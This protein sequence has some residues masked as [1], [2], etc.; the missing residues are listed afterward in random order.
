MGAIP[1]DGTCLSR[2]AMAPLSRSLAAPAGIKERLS[3]ESVIGIQRGDEGKGKVACYLVQKAVR[4]G[5][6]TVVARGAGGDN[7]GHTRVTDQGVKVATHLIPASSSI[8]GVSA[9]I[10]GAGTVVSLE[11]LQKEAAEIAPL[12][13]DLTIYIAGNCTLVTAE[14]RRRDAE[15]MKRIGSTGRGIGPAMVDLVNRVGTLVSSVDPKEFP[16]CL[17]VKVYE[18]IFDILPMDRR[19]KVIMENPQGAS[20][21]INRGTYPYVTSSGTGTAVAVG[22]AGLPMCCVTRIF[23]VAKAYRTS[24]GVDPKPQVMGDEMSSLLAEVGRE[25]GVTTGRRRRVDYLDASEII[26]YG[27]EEGV[28][29]LCVTKVDL[30]PETMGDIDSAYQYLGSDGKTVQTGSVSGALTT[31]L[32]Q[33]VMPVADTSMVVMIGTG[34]RDS[35]VEWWNLVVPA[36]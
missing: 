12:N 14:H 1:S 36:Y 20:L 7:C 2:P 19:V 17:P 26:R 27:R 13:P 10:I 24:V 23:G 9:V 5:Y 25:F 33:S 31:I 35:D 22:Q 30:L 21:D 8:V 18:S 3:I 34:P 29:D 11:A 28:T 15:N 6:H 32:S 4:D 16:T